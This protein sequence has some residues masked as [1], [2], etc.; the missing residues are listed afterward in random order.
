MISELKE[1]LDRVEKK[2]K[3]LRGYL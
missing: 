1:E 2:L 3:A